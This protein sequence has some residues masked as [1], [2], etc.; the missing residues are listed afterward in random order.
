[1]R[2]IPLLCRLAARLPLGLR[3]RT[4]HRLGLAALH[5]HRWSEA[6]ALFDR[7]A[8]RYREEIEV[9]ALA[10]VRA[11][12]GIAQLRA[13]AVQ[14]PQQILEVERRLYR[15]RSIEALEPPFALIDA[16]RLLAAWAPHAPVRVPLE[17]RVVRL[18]RPN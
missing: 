1:M 5:A 6:D 2:F 10:R 3:G 12:Q 15:L 13:S 7:A 8:L 17:L 9:E 11:H 16:G 18:P 4:L 14:D